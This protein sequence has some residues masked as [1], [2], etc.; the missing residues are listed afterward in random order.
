MS[1]SSILK[2]SC[3]FGVNGMCCDCGAASSTSGSWRELMGENRG[4]AREGGTIHALTKIGWILDAIR[5]MIDA[6][7]DNFSSGDIIFWNATVTLSQQGD[8][9]ANA[10][11]VAFLYFPISCLGADC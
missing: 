6:A 4:D 1:I 8:P 7:H 3:S 10:L 2:S 9:N 11:A 5:W